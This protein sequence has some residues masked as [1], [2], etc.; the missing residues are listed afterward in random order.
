MK[1]MLI[2]TGIMLTTLMNF[3]QAEDIRTP[4]YVAADRHQELLAEM[5]GFLVSIN[6]IVRGLAT[7]DMATVAKFA[8]ANGR[9]KMRQDRIK[10]GRRGRG[11]DAPQPFQMMG[12]T[13]HGKFDEIALDAEQMGDP[14]QTLEQLAATTAIC[15]ACHAS[16]RF[17]SK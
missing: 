13:L 8:R 11:F 7:E 6:G 16:Y 2:A 1:K 9:L 3:A 5:R 15:T 17:V 10:S 4:I 14:Q 12:G